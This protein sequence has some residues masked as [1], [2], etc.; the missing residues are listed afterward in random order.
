[1]SWGVSGVLGEE[2]VTQASTQVDDQLRSGDSQAEEFARQD[3]ELV[4]SAL[5]TLV[6]TA[7]EGS[8]FSIG[9]HRNADGSG[10]CYLNIE[11]AAIAQPQEAQP[12]A[13]PDVPHSSR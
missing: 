13:R 10:N 6:P 4:L 2:Q 11:H 5:Q 12:D 7:R 1:M 8:R 9:G 3:A